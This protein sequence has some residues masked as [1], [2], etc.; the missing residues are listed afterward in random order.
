MSEPTE[1]DWLEGL[2]PDDRERLRDE[3]QGIVDGFTAD[4]EA[5]NTALIESTNPLVADGYTEAEAE[6]ARKEVERRYPNAPVLRLYRE[7]VFP[8]S[9][10]DGT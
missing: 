4:L 8:R 1:R 6:I 5:V 3:L 7:R 2:R 10:V 9:G